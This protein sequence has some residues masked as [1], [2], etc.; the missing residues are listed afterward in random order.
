[1][2]QTDIFQAQLQL[3]L[4]T[5]EQLQKD[6]AR[7]NDFILGLTKSSGDRSLDERL[8]AEIKEEL[9]CG[10]AEGTFDPSSLECGA[11]ISR[12]FAL[13]QVSKT[14]MTD[15][16]SISGV[17]DS[18]IIHNKIDLHLVDMFAAAIKC[19]LSA[20]RAHAV[21]GSL[22]GKTYDLKSAYR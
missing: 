13:V 11:T 19:Y 4:M 10:R 2:E 21:D 5:M 7:R 3:C 16:F 15:D 18:C 1:M 20:C 8:L 22:V 9:D 6:A 14:M 17:N 12:R